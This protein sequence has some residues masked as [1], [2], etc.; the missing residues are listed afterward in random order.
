MYEGALRVPFM[1]QWK[2]VIPAGKVYEN[3]VSS[4]D[5]FATAAANCAG[6]AQ[7]GQVE[8]VN[9]VPHLTG[10]AD[11][12]P[13]E[14]LYWRQGGKTALRHGDWKLLR[15]GQ[16]FVP[17]NAQWELYDLSRDVSEENNLAASSP[18]RVAALVTI[19]EK[20]DGEMSEPAFGGQGSQAR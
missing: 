16:R 10:R 5:I 13:H 18:E 8:G 12:V 20:L 7:S 17:G 11:G 15:M 2:G 1:V 19:W 14:T 4:L 6:V 9:L 3:P